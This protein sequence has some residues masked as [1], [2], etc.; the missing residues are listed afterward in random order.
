MRDQLL[1][2]A[3]RIQREVDELQRTKNAAL[4][5]WQKALT[6]EDYVGSV[7]FDLQ[8]FYQGVERIF[9]AIGKLIDTNVPVGEGWHKALLSQMTDEVPGVRPAVISPNT[10]DVLDDFR[11]FRHIARNI[12]AFNLDVARLRILVDKLPEAVERICEDLFVFV[13][14]L[15]KSVTSKKRGTSIN[16]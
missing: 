16:K 11:K 2:L 14:F 9:E 13:G 5:K 12:Y 4:R 10:R 8:S 7:A 1:Q 3:K 6:D 15:K